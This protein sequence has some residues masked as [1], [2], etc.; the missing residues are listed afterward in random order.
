M[1]WLKENWFKV[2]ILLSVF[3]FI[4]PFYYYYILYLPDQ[5]E[6]KTQQ[7][8]ALQLS[9]ESRR[10]SNERQREACLLVAQ[11]DYIDNWASQCKSF[12]VNNKG[13]D[14]TLPGRNADRVEQWRKES[15]DECYKKYPVR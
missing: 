14:C 4:W 15:K 5:H 7:E 11:T 1:N 9:E 6:K 13:K 2:G 3:L 10:A 12:G 8:T